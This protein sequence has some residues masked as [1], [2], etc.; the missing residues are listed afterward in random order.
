MSI[1]I[2]DDDFIIFFIYK[3][4]VKG[5]SD[6][7]EFKRI[8][9]NKKQVNIAEIISSIANTKSGILFIGWDEELKDFSS[10][11]LETTEQKVVQANSLIVPLL[12]IEIKKI[13]NNIGK[14]L[15]V[16]IPNDKAIHSVYG[17]FFYRSGSHKM[18][19][20]LNDI[21]NKEAEISSLPI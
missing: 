15:V 1:N 14:F 19:L 13:S 17:K 9:E 11:D 12:N 18:E 7:I 8:I 20:D 10:I 16:S 5:D 4:G 2:F 3:E 21:S 6:I